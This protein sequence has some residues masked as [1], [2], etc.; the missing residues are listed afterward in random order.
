[1]LYSRSQIH[2]SAFKIGTEFIT[3]TGR[4]RCTDVGTRTIAAIKL[5]LDH[6]KSWYS[7]PSYSVAENVFDEEGIIDCEPAPPETIYDDTAKNRLVTIDTKRRPKSPFHR[8]L[9][10][11]YTVIFVRDMTAMRHFY[12]KVL[13]FRLLRELSE[14]WVEYQIGSNTLA[15]AK[16]KLIASDPPTPHGSASLQIAFRVSVAEVDTCADELVRNGV[17]LLSPPTNQS[18]G[19]RTVFFRDPDGNLL[20][21]FADI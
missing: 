11:D 8:I 21:I 19:H 15:L 18:F 2:H 1:M 14:N 13:D 5:D 16:P 3:E 17:D 20:E 4:W 12:R 7:G 6:D 10:I 9:A